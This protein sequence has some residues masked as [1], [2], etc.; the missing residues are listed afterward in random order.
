LIFEYFSN[1][2]VFLKSAKRTA[3]LDEGYVHFSI[4]L[5]SENEMLRAKVVEKNGFYVFFKE[6]RALYVKK[7]G[8]ARQATDGNIIRHIRFECRITKSTD[9]Q[10]YCI[11]TVTM[12]TRTCLKVTY[13]YIAWPF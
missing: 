11:S 9:T 4:S 10:Y 13:T 3:T 2:Q 8:R 7:Y 1:I 6:N 12:V 5:K